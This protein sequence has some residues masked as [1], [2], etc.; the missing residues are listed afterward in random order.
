MPER[1]AKRG[2]GNKNPPTNFGAEVILIR[3]DYKIANMQLGRERLLDDD[4][5][6]RLGAASR[7][8]SWVLIEGEEGIQEICNQYATAISLS[9]T[10]DRKD[11]TEDEFREVIYSRLIAA[12]HRDL[13]IIND[14][15]MY[16]AVGRIL[17]ELLGQDIKTIR[18]GLNNS[19]LKRL[20]LESWRLY[21]GNQQ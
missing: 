8:T 21:S 17:E 10:A 16:I 19:S 7:K 9:P 4:L 15:S 13:D 14:P 20:V 2:A 11:M 1:E 6:R 12:S 18:G 5:D 3:K